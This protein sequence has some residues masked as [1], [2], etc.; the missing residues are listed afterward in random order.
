MTGCKQK[1]CMKENIGYQFLEMFKV[2]FIC[3][4]SQCLDL[5]TTY[6]WTYCESKSGY[7]FHFCYWELQE[8]QKTV[9]HCQ[10]DHQMISSDGN[11]VIDLKERSKTVPEPFVTAI[12]KYLFN[13]FIKFRWYYLYTVAWYACLCIAH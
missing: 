9:L 10:L 3:F 1:Y 7:C 11:F 12:W 13:I 8:V 2:I 4:Q 5:T 6:G